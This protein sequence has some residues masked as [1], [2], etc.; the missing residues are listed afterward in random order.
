[1]IAVSTFI[2]AILTEEGFFRGWLWASLERAGQRPNRVLVW[3]S[4][5]FAVWHLSVVLF[6][7]D[8][9]VPA[10]QV[11]V[12]IVNAAV[13]GAVWGLLRWISGSVIVASLSHGV[14]NGGAYVFFGFGTTVGALGIQETAVY[15]PEVGFVGLALNL[16][17]AAALLWWWKTRAGGARGV[18]HRQP[19]RV[20]ELDVGD[21]DER[22]PSREGRSTTTRS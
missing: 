1:L 6:E 22:Q 2:G 7:T 4:I 11:P 5:A 12:Y 16:A 19:F 20:H 17:F 13:I 15:G 18:A 14:W 9:D 10:P 3:S 21:S 8:F